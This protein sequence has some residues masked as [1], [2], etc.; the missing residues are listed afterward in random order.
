M[1][2]KART[3]PHPALLKVTKMGL[4]GFNNTLG[5]DW[6]VAVQWPDDVKCVEPNA[7]ETSVSPCF[8]CANFLVFQWPEGVITRRYTP[9]SLS[10]KSPLLSG[11]FYL[12]L[13]V[14]H[15]HFCISAAPARPA[16]PPGLHSL[17]LPC[18]PCKSLQSC[19]IRKQVRLLGQLS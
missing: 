9:S 16:S 6:P 10:G 4:C 14:K 12:L 17:H 19:V 15:E 7:S 3:R 5:S 2:S 11:S 8:F 13:C 18:S 1:S